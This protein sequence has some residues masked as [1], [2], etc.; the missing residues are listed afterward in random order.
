MKSS[1]NKSEIKLGKKERQNLL[2][3]IGEGNYLSNLAY[4]IGQDSSIPQNWRNK[5]EQFRKRWDNQ[6]TQC[7]KIINKLC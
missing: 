5:M 4:N 3:L 1:K 6:F 7:E 2:N